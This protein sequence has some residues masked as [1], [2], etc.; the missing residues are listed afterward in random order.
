MDNSNFLS[1][2]SALTEANSKE[3]IVA[4][5]NNIINSISLTSSTEVKNEKY[6]DYMKI[7]K[8]PSEDLLYTVRR[9]IGGLSS[10]GVEFRKGFSLTFSLLISKFGKDL[11]MK[12]ILD[13]VQKES[14][15]P[16]NEK[17]HIK[18]C[19]FS[20]RILMYRIILNEK[21]LSSDNILFIL[22]QVLNIT[23]NKSLEES[24]IVLLKEMFRKIF[25]NYYTEIKN[26]NKLYDGMFKLL[27]NYT[28]NKNSLNKVNS[29]FEFAIYFMLI[30]YM[31]KF[32]G[33]LPTNIKKEMFDSSFEEAESPL[34]K[35]FD[36]I[37]KL[38]IKEGKE[39]NVTFGCLCEL[40]EKI[41][42]KKYAYKIWNILIDQKCIESFKAISLKNFEL[43]IYNYSSFIL[44][45][46]FEIDYIV[47]IF[48]DSFFISLLKFSSNKK[49]KYVSSLTEIITN[50][51]TSKKYDNNVINSYCE[52]LLRIFGVES[53][54]KYSPN[55]LK[56][57]F[58]FLFDHIAQDAK[59]KYIASLINDSQKEDEEENLEQLIFR[60]SALKTLFLFDTTLDESQRTKIINFFLQTFYASS[61]DVDIEL[62]HIIEERTTLL[63][64]S[65]I[66]PTMSNGEIVQLKQSKAIK[67]LIDL[68]KSNIQ[69]LIKGKKIILN[70]KNYMKY[71]KQ[72]SKE[73]KESD[74]KSKLLTKLGLVLLVFYL[75][76]E[77]DYQQEIE[78]IIEIKKFDREW[79]KMYTD[80]TLNIMH[81]G[82]VMLSEFAMG[83]Y[84]KMSKHIGKEGVD[85]LIQFLKDTK[86]KK[87][88]N[89]MLL[90]DDEDM[91]M[92]DK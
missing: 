60:I 19:A 37:M 87:E 12:E 23:V 85:I 42:D 28:G 57:F 24:V 65:L 9:L 90:S 33:F 74:L 16:K 78:D 20:G 88:K 10:T 76:N 7:C 27:D 59:E 86:P 53:E 56:T 47:Q 77:I 32:K 45:K 48:D 17:N 61:P 55:A 25:E 83:I 75:K 72:F 22:K 3:V 63:I 40:I 71:Y 46:F 82:N 1:Y 39:F 50:K 70:S 66:K 14:F 36:I 8:N 34:K 18:T 91:S 11:N 44:T 80:L 21:S 43:L 52:K 58:I 81:K 67:I 35:Y 4:N 62:D 5:A 69:S 89:P 38:P 6:K 64:L 84:K 54:D 2:F 30:L 49:F 92:E 15:V 51:L 73:E 68:H 13:C 41:N 31:D 79:S 26:E 29:N